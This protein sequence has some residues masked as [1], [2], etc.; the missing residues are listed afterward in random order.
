[1]LATSQGVLPRTLTTTSPCEGETAI[2]EPINI[3]RVAILTRRSFLR[4]YK[5]QPR[6]S[7]GEDVLIDGVPDNWARDLLCQ[8]GARGVEPSYSLISRISTCMLRTPA[9]NILR[10]KNA[11]SIG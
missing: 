2:Y 9:I 8:L 6:P 3:T 11:S 5:L 10:D 7:D 4:E 1:M